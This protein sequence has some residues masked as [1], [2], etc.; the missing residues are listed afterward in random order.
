[1][2]SIPTPGSNF[3]NFLSTPHGKE[4]AQLKPRLGILIYESNEERIM[5]INDV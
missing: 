3:Q 5:Q 2:N 4:F 1:M